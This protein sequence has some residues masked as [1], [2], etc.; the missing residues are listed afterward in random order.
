M[1]NDKDGIR[2]T[3]SVDRGKVATTAKKTPTEDNRTEND[4]ER[5]ETDAG[6]TQE[7]E[8]YVACAAR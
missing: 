5:E 1:T 3:A 2:S 7:E 4:A 6:D 8:E